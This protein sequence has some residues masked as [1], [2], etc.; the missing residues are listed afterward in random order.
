MKRWKAAIIAYLAGCYITS[1]AYLCVCFFHDPHRLEWD[2]VSTILITLAP[3][4][5][6]YQ[7]VLMPSG[8]VVGLH[9]VVFTPIAILTYTIL[10]RA[11][12][13]EKGWTE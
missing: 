1:A 6:P 8:F 13:G 9:L 10:R 11:R 2:S 12:R 4:T 3:I 7:V 5:V